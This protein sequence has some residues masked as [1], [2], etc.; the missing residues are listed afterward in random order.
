MLPV[1][2]KTTQFSSGEIAGLVSAIAGGCGLVKG[3]FSPVSREITNKASGLP[4]PGE[5][6]TTRH[7]LS[8]HHARYVGVTQI[9]PPTRISASLRSVPP[10]GGI[11]RNSLLPAS[12]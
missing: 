4:S 12:D 7:L 2:R 6:V 9:P 8:G 10:N 1:R 11:S 5:S 3:F